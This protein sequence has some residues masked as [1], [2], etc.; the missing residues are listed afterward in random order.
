MP[1][2]F[3]LPSLGFSSGLLDKIELAPLPPLGV[4]RRDDRFLEAIDHWVANPTLGRTAGAGS[5]TVEVTA[6]SGQQAANGKHSLLEAALRLLAGDLDTAH[7]ISQEIASR[8]GSFWHGVMHRREGDY[9]NAKY[10]FRRVGE[11]PA[12]RTLGKEL[13]GEP[14]TC[15]LFA[16]GWD[17]ESFVDMC[18]VACRRGGEGTSTYETLAQAQWIEW[19]VMVGHLLS[20]GR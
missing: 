2:L 11:H 3:L 12:Y 5:A 18:A 8:D 13:A 9:S 19:Q 20:V 1:K 16:D 4:G 15:E 17:A 10:W 7:R 14:L 6:E